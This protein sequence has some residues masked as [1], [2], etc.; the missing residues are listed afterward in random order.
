[1]GCQASTCVACQGS[2]HSLCPPVS[3]SSTWRVS[4]TRWAGQPRAGPGHHLPS[5]LFLPPALAVISL[6]QVHVILH[7][8]CSFLQCRWQV[9]LGSSVCVLTVVI[10]SVRSEHSLDLVGPWFCHLCLQSIPPLKDL[11]AQYTAQPPQSHISHPCGC[12]TRLSLPSSER[13]RYQ[14][15]DPGP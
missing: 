6:N 11:R 12:T 14:Q 9:S 1:M 5:S 7:P 15:K 3:F 13:Q 8:L 10:G 2:G 4:G